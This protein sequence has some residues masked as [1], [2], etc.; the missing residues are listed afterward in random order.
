MPLK[1]IMRIA[2]FRAAL[3]EFE[4]HSEQV[5]RRWE[6][7]PQRYLLLLAIKGAPDGSQRASLTQLT[8]R[9]QLGANTVTELVAR[10]EQTG[11]VQRERAQ[12][13]RRIVHLS[14]TR[15]GERRLLGALT[16]SDELRRELAAAFD[17][18]VAG[19][20]SARRR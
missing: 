4:R 19:F 11:L 14:L 7:T 6:L 17:S 9:L 2:E 1:R 15:E 18:L 20:H 12:H 13:D 5:A 3:R 10:A 16:E 8:R